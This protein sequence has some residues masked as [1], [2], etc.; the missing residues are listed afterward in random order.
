MFL[1]IESTTSMRYVWISCIMQFPVNGMDS[2]VVI[3][4]F[5]GQAINAK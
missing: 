3:K 2:T 4:C 5:K 1:D